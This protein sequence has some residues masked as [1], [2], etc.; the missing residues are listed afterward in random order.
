[1]ILQNSIIL[2]TQAMD[3]GNKGSEDLGGW[4]GVGRKRVKGDKGMGD[5]WNTF[6]NKK[7]LKKNKKQKNTYNII[8][9]FIMG[10]KNL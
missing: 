4:V 5:I 9:D 6:N 1:M 3:M 7:I 2:H 8:L 10:S